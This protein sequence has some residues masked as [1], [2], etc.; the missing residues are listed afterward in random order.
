MIARSENYARSSKKKSREFRL[1]NCSVRVSGPPLP[2]SSPPASSRYSSGKVPEGGRGR[3]RPTVPAKGS[4]QRSRPTAP[5]NGPDALS[6]CS[7]GAERPGH[8]SRCSFGVPFR[9][10][11]G[12]HL[13]RAI[14]S[15][16]HLNSANSSRRFTPS[17]SFH[18]VN[19]PISWVGRV[20]VPT[21]FDHSIASPPRMP[22]RCGVCV[23]IPARGHRPRSWGRWSPLCPGF[24]FVPRN[25][26][27]SMILN[28]EE[29][30][31]GSRSSFVS[32]YR[33]WKPIQSLLSD[34]SLG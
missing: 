1:L 25:E 24:G 13:F 33:I 22:G 11:E 29:H 7:F 4:G 27:P 28:N 8:R 21:R 12:S 20:L 31:D 23:I 14:Y 30:Q 15:K 16:R 34:A 26:F 5:T 17:A 10:R 6:G 32:Q 9:E 2:I 19:H 3:F 18:R